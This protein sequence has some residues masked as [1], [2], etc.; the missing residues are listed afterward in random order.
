M[1]IEVSSLG[2]LKAAH[3]AEEEAPS[4]ATLLRAS[5]TPLPPIDNAVC[6]YCEREGILL[7]GDLTTIWARIGVHLF[8]AQH[9]RVKRRKP[10]RRKGAINSRYRDTDEKIMEIVEELSLERPE[11]P[12]RILTAAVRQFE[13]RGGLP[14]AE[15]TTHPTRLRQKWRTRHSTDRAVARD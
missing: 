6:E 15:R 8:Q 11:P 2:L 4:L 14:A 1:A 9:D 7:D 5:P 13:K 3:P 12:E 10:G